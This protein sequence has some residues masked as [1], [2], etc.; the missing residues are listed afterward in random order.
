MVFRRKVG[1]RQCIYVQFIFTYCPVTSN[2]C[3]CSFW[4]KQNALHL[5]MLNKV[6]AVISSWWKSISEFIR[7]IAC[8]MGSHDVTCHPTQANT[9]SLNPS[10][11]RL[12]LDL[13]TTEGW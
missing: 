13:P 11:W 4:K 9:P 1:R 3:A 7:G 6:K 12:E 5:D 10:Q 2:F 8:H